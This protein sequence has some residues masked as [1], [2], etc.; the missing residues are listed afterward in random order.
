MIASERSTASIGNTKS[1]D[2]WLIVKTTQYSYCYSYNKNSMALWQPCPLKN[3]RLSSNW[4][5]ML[6]FQNPS[7]P[8]DP[9]SLLTLSHHEKKI[10]HS[11]I[12]LPTKKSSAQWMTAI[13]GA[14]IRC[15]LFWDVPKHISIS[16]YQLDPLTLHEK[17]ATNPRNLTNWYQKWQ[18]FQKEPPFPRPI[19][20]GPSSRYSSF[21]GMYLS[22]LAS[23]LR[24]AEL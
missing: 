20:L 4:K 24:S 15:S 12:A 2:F 18:D 5:R 23:R 16:A 14:G 19:I 1:C 8:N 17:M 11:N 6:W 3:T 10:M 13:R 7:C 9:W 21:S 22:R